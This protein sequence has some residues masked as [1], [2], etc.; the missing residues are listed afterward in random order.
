MWAS[1]AVD[2]AGKIHVAYQD[3]LGDELMY[4]TW[5]GSAGT[6]EV[7][8]DGQ[9]MGERTHTVGAGA[10]IYLRG[11]TPVIAYQDGTTA[12]VVLAARGTPSWTVTPL[13]TGPLLD[14]FHLA[15]TAGR[16]SPTLAWQALDPALA[17][18]STLVIKAAP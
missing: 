13:V 2:G 6:P 16:P 7:V 15:V 14:G 3:A 9:R 8:D 10:R 4:T 18:T 5:S 11:G 17:P 12:D 1:A